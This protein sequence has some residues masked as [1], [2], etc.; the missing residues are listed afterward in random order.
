[1]PHL[2]PTRECV[3]IACVDRSTLPELEPAELRVIAGLA[4]GLD[5]RTVEKY[6]RG[7][8]TNRR[9][10]RAIERALRESGRAAYI[11]RP[12]LAKA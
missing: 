11:R 7:L 6:L 5:Q 4:G 12:S 2:Q 3:Y 9:K 1:M 10:R 8:T